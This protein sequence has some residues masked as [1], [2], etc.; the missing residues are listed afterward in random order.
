[1]GTSLSSYIQVTFKYPP[2]YFPQS[3]VIEDLC[4]HSICFTFHI[5]ANERRY[6]PEQL[7]SNN[8]FIALKIPRHLLHKGKNIPCTCNLSFNHNFSLP[9]ASLQV[10]AI[11][12]NQFPHNCIKLNFI[13][14]IRLYCA[15]CLSRKR[16]Q[17]PLGDLSLRTCLI[18]NLST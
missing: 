2:G 18:S 16:Y 12:G 5:C 7:V 11:N 6:S 10:K 8:C 13:D 17:I 14:R 9:A 15:T 4:S 1:M 3:S